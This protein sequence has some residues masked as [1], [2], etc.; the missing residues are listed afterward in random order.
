MTTP[1]ASALA[2][3]VPGRI[4]RVQAA[5]RDA[6]VDALLVHGHG[7]PDGMGLVRYLANARAWAGR[8]YAVLGRTDPDPGVLSHSGYQAA[9]TRAAVLRQTEK[10]DIPS[11]HIRRT[12]AHQL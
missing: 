12:A 4:A 3:D 6:G 5:M 10:V 8:I 2:A 7:S 9:W 1:I 11:D